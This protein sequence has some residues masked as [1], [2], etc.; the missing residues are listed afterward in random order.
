MINQLEEVTNI[1]KFKRGFQK[2]K[3]FQHRFAICQMGGL[4]TKCLKKKL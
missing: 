4:T 2:I 3:S 1:L